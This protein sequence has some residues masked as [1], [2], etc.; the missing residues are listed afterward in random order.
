M[1]TQKPPFRNPTCIVNMN[2][3]EEF[4]QN[5]TKSMDITVLGPANPNV[6]VIQELIE[7]AYDQ[8]QMIEYLDSRIIDLERMVYAKV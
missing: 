1:S 2:S 7:S 5:Y 8:Q 3:C 6:R 4:V